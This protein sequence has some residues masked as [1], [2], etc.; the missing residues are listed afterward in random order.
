MQR[1]RLGTDYAGVRQ[2]KQVRERRSQAGDTFRQQGIHRRRVFF[3]LRLSGAERAA[4]ANRRTAF[5]LHLAD[6]REREKLQKRIAQ[7]ENKL[8]REKQFKRQ[9]ELRAEIKRLV[10]SGQ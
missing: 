1:G 4:L 6:A 2:Y 10:D 8:L 5:H 3:H 9:M 7:L